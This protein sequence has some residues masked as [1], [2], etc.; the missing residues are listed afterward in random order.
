MRD[1][2]TSTYKC[3][4]VAIKGISGMEADNLVAADV[5]GYTVVVTKGCKVGDIGVY[6]PVGCVMP[7]NNRGVEIKKIRGVYSEGI[8]LPWGVVVGELVKK[9]LSEASIVRLCE[10]GRDVGPALGIS[11]YAPEGF[12]GSRANL[13]AVKG[14]SFHKYTRL[15]ELA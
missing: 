9:G 11:R 7:D 8:W 12:K 10:L 4:V 3:P 15:Q 2:S 13:V 6:V 5:L 14:D 1:T